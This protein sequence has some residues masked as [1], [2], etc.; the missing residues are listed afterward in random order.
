[1]VYI[2][3]YS[4][5]LLIHTV[6]SAE[7]RRCVCTAFFPWEEVTSDAEAPMAGLQSLRPA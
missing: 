6:K 4:I 5:N 7:G 3:A 2:S 1:M